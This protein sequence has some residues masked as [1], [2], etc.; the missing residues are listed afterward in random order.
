M[1]NQL[2]SKRTIAL[3]SLMLIAMLAVAGCSGGAVATATPPTPVAEA[4]VAPPAEGAAAAVSAAP[5][6]GVRTFVIDT[7]ASSASYLADETFLGG[8]LEKLGIA[9]GESDVVGVTQSLEGQLQLDLSDLS[10]ALGDNRFTVRLDT[11]E[12][13]EPRRDSWIRE[14]GPRFNDYPLAT[15][16]ATTVSGGPTSYTEGEEVS[17]E[18]S[19]DI[20]IR[21][22]TRPATFAV[23]AKL[24]GDTLT[25]VAT[26]RLKMSDFGIEPLNFANTLTVEDEFGIRV[27]FTAKG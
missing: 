17:F 11:L 10:A 8:A 1:M 13:G 21:E 7:A 22:L 6:T 15:F 2:R 4:T 9:A 27:E 20:T 24:A 26:T 16:V 19:G 25:G 14:N 18:L 5:V 3:S 12:T 23:T